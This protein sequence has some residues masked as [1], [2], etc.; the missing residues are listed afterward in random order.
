MTERQLF[1]ILS[2]RTYTAPPFGSLVPA[3]LSP[4]DH[5]GQPTGG[6]DPDLPGFA[7]PKP[8]T[9][10]DPEVVVVFLNRK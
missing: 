1:Q 10:A 5:V 3:T 7:M 6:R 9:S 8:I 4:G 2:R